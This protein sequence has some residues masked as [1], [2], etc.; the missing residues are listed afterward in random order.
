MRRGNMPTSTEGQ[1]EVRQNRCE[2]QRG[3]DQNEIAAGFGPSA[4]RECRKDARESGIYMH[5]RHT[6]GAL[7]ATL[8]PRR[9]K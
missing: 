3:Q 4:E 2:Q 7:A 9:T 6:V 8:E 5:D 1:R